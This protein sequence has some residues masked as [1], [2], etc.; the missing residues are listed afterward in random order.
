MPQ[1]LL[2][3]PDLLAHPP[4]QLR[5]QVRERL[6]EQQDL[7]AQHDRTGDRHP[8]LLTAGELARQPRA[9][10]RE[11]HECQSLLRPGPDLRLAHAADREAVADILGDGEVREEG[12]GL[13][14][15]GDV[16][17]RR[18]QCGHVLP[19]DQDAPRGRK[20]EASDHAQGGGLAAAGRTQERHE[21]AGPDLERHLAH[22]DHGAEGLGYPLEL[23]GGGLAHAGCACA[24]AGATRLPSWRSPTASCMSAMIASITRIRT[25]E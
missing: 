17:R 15:H 12:V 23:D 2:Q 4:A 11:A 9:V 22:R 1:R 3:V 20:L 25:E 8:L 13:E 18:R 7:R 16:A 10:A 14:D 5:V 19:A 21:V 24:S 6:V